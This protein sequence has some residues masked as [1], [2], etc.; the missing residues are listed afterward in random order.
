MLT[1][2]TAKKNW[3]FGHMVK[4]VEASRTFLVPPRVLY[5]AFIDGKDL[6]RMLMSPAA[7]EPRVG[8]SFTFFNGGVSGNIVELEANTRIVE[9]WRFSQWE[10]DCYSTLEIAFIPAGSERTKMVVRQTEI[11]STDK[12][13]NGNQDQLVLNG[14]NDRFFMGLEK[15]LGFPVDRD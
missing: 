6:S 8:G 14:W 5:Q 7:I 2:C 15:V 12:H 11:P 9:K 13:G 10:D 4:S 3:G 1:Q